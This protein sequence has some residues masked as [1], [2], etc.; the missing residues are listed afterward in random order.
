MINSFLIETPDRVRYL[1]F[2]TVFQRKHLMTACGV[3]RI[4]DGEPRLTSTAA[5]TFDALLAAAEQSGLC[6]ANL[7]LLEIARLRGAEGR[8]V[9]L[10]EEADHGDAVFFICRDDRIYD[11]AVAALKVKYEPRGSD[12]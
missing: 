12:Q 7:R 8:V 3:G 1:V 4:K 10:L 9:K 11:A 6:T 2:D 5:A